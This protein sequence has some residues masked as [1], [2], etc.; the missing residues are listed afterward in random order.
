MSWNGTVRCSICYR[1][2]HNKSGCPQ[3]A[4]E[5]KQFQDILAKYNAANPDKPDVEEDQY[6]GWDLKQRIGLKYHHIRSR[7]ILLTKKRKNTKRQCTYCGES[8]HNR[9]SCGPL[10]ND[11]DLLVRA[12]AAYGKL[13]AKGFEY[14]GLY[15]GALIKYEDR[16]YDYKKCKYVNIDTM[17]V[18]TNINLTGY[19]I[20]RWLTQKWQTHHSV[21]IMTSNGD[22]YKI[23]PVLSPAFKESLYAGYRW[24]STNYTVLSSKG[25]PVPPHTFDTKE[26]I[27]FIKDYL[28]EYKVDLV[29]ENRD[30]IAALINGDS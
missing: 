30:R 6:I 24:S 7:D 12:S 17:A 14:A 28:K 20:M 16:Q 1:S 8:G 22:T 9:R 25:T 3:V 23:Q 29:K 26:H 21:S 13:L 19:D 5:Y 10:K 15:A 27:A 18:V 11:V 2:G 4:E